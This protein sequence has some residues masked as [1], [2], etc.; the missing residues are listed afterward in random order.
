MAARSALWVRRGT[1]SAGSCRGGARLDVSLY[2]EAVSH[3]LVMIEAS[4]ASFRGG[5]DDDITIAA[6]GLNA[7]LN[8]QGA[9]RRLVVVERYP[10]SFHLRFDSHSCFSFP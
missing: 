4:S 3:R 9:S 2:L 6:P 8:L 7:T 1:R 5:P 10:A